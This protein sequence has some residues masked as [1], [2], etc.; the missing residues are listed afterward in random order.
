MWYSG[1]G[2]SHDCGVGVVVL[3]TVLCG[4]GEGSDSRDCGVG[5]VALVTTVLCGIGGS[6]GGVRLRGKLICRA[7]IS[8]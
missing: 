8:S 3:D 2:D 7:A 1:V 6:T 4:I 5:V